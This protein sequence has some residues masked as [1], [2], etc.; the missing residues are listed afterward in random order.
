MKRIS[1]K[2]MCRLLESRDWYLLRVSGSHHVYRSDA[3]N[4]QVSVPVHANRDLRV[5]TQH[6]IMRDAGISDADL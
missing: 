3:L 1:G 2:R 4:R 5:G 6:R